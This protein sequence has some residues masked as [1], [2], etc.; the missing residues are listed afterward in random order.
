MQAE[1]M[2]SRLTTDYDLLPDGGRPLNEPTFETTK[3]FKEVQIHPTD[4]KK[5]TTIATNMDL[6]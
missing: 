5:T 1:Y 4:P 3:N 6:A 2:A